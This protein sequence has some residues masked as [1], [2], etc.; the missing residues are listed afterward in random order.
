[1][2][3]GGACGY[4]SPVQRRVIAAAIAVLV[5]VLAAAQTREAAPAEAQA[6][7]TA[8]TTATRTPTPTATA[9]V[10]TTATTTATATT[11]PGPWPMFQHDPRHTGRSPHS[12]PARVGQL[13]AYDTGVGPMT[14][15]PIVGPD[16]T[17]YIGGGGYLHAFSAGGEALWRLPI[18]N[19]FGTVLQAADGTLYA[20]G[21]AGSTNLVYQIAQDGTILARF[22]AVGSLISPLALAL[23]DDGT[24]YF[25]I[26]NAQGTG[27]V[28]YALTPNQAT[29]VMD[30]RWRLTTGFLAGSQPAV[31]P[32]TGNIYVGTYDVGG[33][34]L[35][36]SPAGA[37]LGRTE[38][39]GYINSSPSIDTDGTIYVGSGTGLYALNTNGL[40]RWV[41]RT[42]VPIN[43][44]SPAIDVD[45][46]VYVGAGDSLLA[47]DRLGRL[48]WQQSCLP[49]GRVNS[50][51]AISAEGLL[52]YQAILPGGVPSAALC[53]TDASG[54]IRWAH[55]TQYNGEN[56]PQVGSPAIGADDVVYVGSPNGVLFALVSAAANPTARVI[57]PYVAR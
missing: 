48:R 42:G 40:V 45:G 37:L 16:G 22:S 32:L 29:G 1:M 18:G 39:L 56:G 38:T 5:L 54:T 46:T 23:A 31:D 25:G 43:Y 26:G 21:L 17:V 24:V 4:A 50:S 15:S 49:G 8:T 36:I 12:A 51:A 19:S 55:Q 27:G 10:T 47:I 44:S 28:L 3:A 9:T 34:L 13:W 20:T 57:L 11:T 53:A 7:A 6:V 35:A 52:Y 41:Y 2:V 33:T 14:G 30:Q